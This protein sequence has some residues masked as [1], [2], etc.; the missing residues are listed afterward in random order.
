[1]AY[2]PERGRLWNVCPRCSRWTLTPL[3]SRWETLEACEAAVREEG[4]VRLST[5][6]LTLVEVMEGELIRVGHPQ[7]PELVDWRYG[8]KLDEA[9]RISGFWDR[10]LSRL[11]SPPVGG[12]DPYR[13]LEG[14]MRSGP[15]LA[16]PF[17]DHASPLTYLFSQIPL[18]PECPSCRGPLALKPWEFQ[19]IEFLPG[20]GIQ[21]IS[22]SCALCKTEVDLSLVDARP[23]L[24][25]GLGLVTP[26]EDLKALSGPAAEGLE[27]LGG[28]TAFL[29]ALST[30][31][32]FLGELDLSSR[33]GLI[34]SLDE[35][36]EMDALEA[37]W[38]E[39]EELASIMDGEL[40]D[41]PGFESFR[42]E[43]L[44]E[45]S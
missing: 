7:R 15:W 22:A 44:E 33:V 6:H 11:P 43:I 25:L 10:L 35:M 23:A 18:A 40:T 12:Y 27:A 19:S 3:E 2:D 28:P 31:R 4:V 36:A 17:L 39:A 20:K 1:M 34:I 45:G 13:G 9:G 21:E 5:L 42:R 26:S 14:A 41:V 37:E 24:R 16:S 30:S 38:R 8:P 32:S 29:R